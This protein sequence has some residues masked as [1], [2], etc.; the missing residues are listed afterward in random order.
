MQTD[1][2]FYHRVWIIGY[3]CNFANGY[4]RPKGTRRVTRQ[5]NM[6][7]LMTGLCLSRAVAPKLA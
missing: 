6:A 4:P 2:P 5:R 7:L 1:H 3:G